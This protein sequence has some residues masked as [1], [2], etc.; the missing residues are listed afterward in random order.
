ML[1]KFLFVIVV[2]FTFC[3][4]FKLG[5]YFSGILISFKMTLPLP[6]NLFLK[7]SSIRLMPNPSPTNFRRR[8]HTIFRKHC[9]TNIVEGFCFT[10]QFLLEKVAMF[11]QYTMQRKCVTCFQY[12]FFILLAIVYSNF[13]CK[14]V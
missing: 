2:C 12:I 11:C 7:C 4:C 1:I 10:N 9:L 3:W 5:V 8:C 14:N 13:P 6:F